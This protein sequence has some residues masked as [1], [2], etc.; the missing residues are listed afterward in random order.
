MPTV[1]RM[2]DYDPKC[3]LVTGGAGF[4]YVVASLN[5]DSLLAILAV[6]LTL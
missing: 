3:V 6:P 5:A 2:A 1:T 4:M